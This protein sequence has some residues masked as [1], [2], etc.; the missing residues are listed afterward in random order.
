[1]RFIVHSLLGLALFFL[2]LICQ[3]QAIDPAGL[4]PILNFEAEQ[5]GGP[6]S[7]WGGSP[8]ETLFTDNKIVHSGKWSARLQRGAAIA[9]SDFSSIT[10][11]IPIDFLGTRPSLR[12]FLK[13][14][15]VSGF[16]GLW[17][18]EDGD[19]GAVAFDS[20][21]NRHVNGTHDWTEFSIALALRPDAKQLVFDVLSRPRFERF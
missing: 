9:N 17:M 2:P 10:I 1:M 3:A 13:L 15:G 14:Q 20:M 4:A 18:R 5:T 8:R 21:E 16:A 7:G 19:G 6:P 11:A 12:G